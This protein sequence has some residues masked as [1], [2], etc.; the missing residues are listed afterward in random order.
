M[1]TRDGL[2]KAAE[3]CESDLYLDYGEGKRIAKKIR[4][5]AAQEPDGWVSVK[6]GLPEL[7]VEILA[8]GLGRNMFNAW[9]Q[10][11]QGGT[12]VDWMMFGRVRLN[13]DNVTHWM[14]PPQ[15]PITDPGSGGQ[16]AT[17]PPSSDSQPPTPDVLLSNP[18]PGIKL[19]SMDEYLGR[20]KPAPAASTNWNAPTNGLIHEPNCSEVDV[21]AVTLPEEPYIVKDLRKSAQPGD[22]NTALVNYVDALRRVAEEAVRENEATQNALLSLGAE[23]GDWQQR[24]ESAKRQLAELRKPGCILVPVSIP[25]IERLLAAAKEGKGMIEDIRR[26]P[27]L[28]QSSTTERPSISAERL[29]EIWLAN[30]F[31]LAVWGGRLMDLAGLR[32]ALREAGVTV[33]GE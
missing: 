27:P 21:P 16:L 6:D 3:I 19:M 2:L 23:L 32:Q 14:S 33:E 12:P 11:E 8:R 4:A 20:G 29:R 22:L 5:R 1:T 18:P 10:P 17:E 25:E 13:N 26:N 28:Y 31:S 7:G 9:R 24:A 30:S 15:P